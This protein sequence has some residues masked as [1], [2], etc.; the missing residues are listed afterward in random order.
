ML[1]N[2]PDNSF[3]TDGG[4]NHESFDHEAFINTGILES[5]VYGIASQEEVEAVERAL[6]LSEN[7]RAALLFVELVA[8]EVAMLDAVAPDPIIKPFLLSTIDVQDRMTAGEVLSPA[9]LLRDGSLPEDFN[10]W[11]KRAD[12]VPPD[13]LEDIFAKIISVTPEAMTAIVWIREMAP[14]E[15]HHDQYER[16]LILEG[17]C[18][19]VV[20]NDV[21]PLQPGSYF[22]IPLHKNHEVI[23]TSSI[24]CKVILQRVAA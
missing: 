10:D 8:E 5:Y 20:E 14:Q 1:N 4:D 23:I 12:M 21:F 2:T 7:V 13:E 6:R 22:Q 16:F 3:P 11:L 17:T 9:P 18:N 24:P 15:V 19:I